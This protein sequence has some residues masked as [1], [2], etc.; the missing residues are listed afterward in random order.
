M[1]IDRFAKCF[2]TLASVLACLSAT[3]ATRAQGGEPPYFAIRGA[4][5]VPVSG[6]VAENATILISRGIIS[7]IGRDL[8]IPDEAW[9]IDGKGLT[10][11]PGL[12]DSFTDVGLT[13]PP[14]EPDRQ[15]SQTPASARARSRP[16]TT[17]WRNAADEISLR[18]GIFLAQRWLHHGSFRAE[19]RIFSPARR[20]C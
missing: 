5:I 13:A 7:A 8:K 19:G 2:V 16:A 6:A 12:I 11:Y 4:K 9:I 17:P 10:V 20:P 1:R 3:P 15:R 18:Q 14:V